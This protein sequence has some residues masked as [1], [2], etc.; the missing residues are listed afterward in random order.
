MTGLPS[1]RDRRQLLAALLGGLGTT[2]ALGLA[3]CSGGGGQSGLG[4]TSALGTEG[5]SS[6]GSKSTPVKVGLLLPLSA[7]TQT[8]L[9]AKAMREAAELALFESRGAELQLV[10]KDDK[11]TED[12]A[13]AAATEAIGQGAEIIL[14]PLF[15]KSVRAAAA[16]AR[17]SSVPVIAFSN[18]PA[19]AGNGAFLIGFSPSVETARIVSFAARAGRRRYAALLPDDAE[20]KLLE[21]AFRA[22]VERAGGAVVFVDRYTVEATGLVSA[23]AGLKDLVQ[24]AK[25]GDEHLDAL[26]LPGGQDTLPQL[27]SLVMQAGIDPTQVKLLGTSGWDF[28]NIQRNSRLVGGWFA[29]PDPDAWAGF[30][31]RYGK[32]Y[33]SVP[34]RIASLAHDAVVL[35]AALAGGAK[36]SRYTDATIA[37]SQ[38]FT[39]ADGAFRFSPAG[40]AE[41]GLAVLEV[42]KAGA[43]VLD[44]P[45]AG[46]WTAPA[47]APIA[48][49][50]VQR[51]TN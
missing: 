28:P 40:I 21:A 48:A 18:D 39:G 41:R 15:A 46:D 43:R 51:S 6:P 50:R 42:Q 14:G 22:A 47:Q 11:G 34:P 16:V 37:R 13:R 5:Q 7:S 32:A 12:G 4:E 44:R 3:G 29:A 27:A 25:R 9:V 26:L 33:R 23:S 38:G 17:K 19:V 45:A 31:E 30:A 20:G 1:S 35:V 49:A 10:I 36:G 24:Q 8:A 2:G